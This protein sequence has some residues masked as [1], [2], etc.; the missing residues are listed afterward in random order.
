M[1]LDRLENADRYAC[2]HL[3]FAPAFRW[4]RSQHLDGLAAQRIE[5]AGRTLFALVS[6]SPGRKRDEA[7]L[8]AHREHIDIQYVIAGTEEMGWKPRSRCQKPATEYNAGDDIEFFSDAQEAYIAV[9]PGT[10]AL[11]F[12]EDAHAPLIG[13]GESHEG[14]FH[15]VVIKVAL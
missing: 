6:K 15:K 5:I 1:I 9:P 2:L 3:D 12:P 4:L 14:E 11:F 10:F 7:R 8:E 13:A